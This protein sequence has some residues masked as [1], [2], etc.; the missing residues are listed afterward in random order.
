MGVSSPSF[1][2]IQKQ[3]FKYLLDNVTNMKIIPITF[4]IILLLSSLSFGVMSGVVSTPEVPQVIAWGEITGTLSNQIDLSNAFQTVFNLSVTNYDII[5]NDITANTIE[6]DLDCSNVTGASYNVCTG[7]GS[8]FSAWGYNYNTLI[9]T[10]NL[11]S[12]VTY[13][14]NTEDLDLENNSLYANKIGVG[15]NLKDSALTVKSIEPT[16]TIDFMS[17][18]YE[19]GI[20]PESSA[21]LSSSNVDKA[22]MVQGDGGAYIMGRDVTN[23]IEFAMGTSSLGTAFAGSTTNHPFQLRV[24][25]SPKLQIATDGDLSI[26]GQ[27]VDVGSGSVSGTT[28]QLTNG[29]Y[30]TPSA[31]NTLGQGDKL[32]SWSSAGT[33]V[34]QGV[35]VGTSYFQ[36]VSSGSGKFEFWNGNTGTGNKNIVIQAN[37]DLD[38]LNGDINLDG[39]QVIHTTSGTYSGVLATYESSAAPSSYNMVMKA[40]TIGGVVR[41]YWD[42]ENQNI[43][44][45]YVLML[46]R[47]GVG[48]NKIPETDM[49]LDVNGNVSISEELTV[50]ENITSAEYILGKNQVIQLHNNITIVQTSANTW[51]NISWN[52]LIDG[53]TTSGYTLEDNN[54]SITFDYEGIV[55][56]QGCL[57]P[58]NNNVG[59]QEAKILVRVL[60][61]NEEAR[62]L[63]A[64]KTKAFKS[65]GVDILEYIGTIKVESGQK[66]QVQWRVDNTDIE[67]RGDTDFD[68]PVSASVNFERISN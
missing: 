10:P 13:T 35:S 31:V 12:Y 11:A 59:N 52:M 23:N 51:K 36:A 18:F 34:A 62:C 7:D 60:I 29:G 39:G 55:R 9:N 33:K 19:N 14:G 48:I 15:D 63:Q 3:K 22:L 61:D 24:A 46:D 1:F 4:I 67:L 2:L 32:V 26:L 41:Y 37:G 16:T 20:T 58:Y 42:I 5:V 27:K 45:P 8:G 47:D 68:N 30:A 54:E 28:L 50:T 66:A 57:H 17:L 53:E 6:G 21:T 44:Y 43:L 38:V 65:T 64:S 56:I 49:A 25:N 40:E